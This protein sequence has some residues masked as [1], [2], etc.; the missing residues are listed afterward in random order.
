M[1]QLDW[2]ILMIL[3][4]GFLIGLFKGFVKQFISLVCIIAGITVAKVFAPSLAG[5]FEENYSNI[6]YGVSFAIIMLAVLIVGVL[7]ANAIRKLLSSA[8]LGWINRLL[9]GLLGSFKYLVIIGV[10]INLMEIVEIDKKVFPENFASKS[11]FYDISKQSLGVLMPF[12]ESVCDATNELIDKSGL[13]E[14]L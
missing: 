13:K 8:D 5:M 14:H 12:Y 9:G 10:V 7:I 6:V 1:E 4:L 11:H 2:V 3:C